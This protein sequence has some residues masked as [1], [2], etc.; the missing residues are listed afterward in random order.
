MINQRMRDIGVI[1]AAGC[2]TPRLFAYSLTEALLVFLA[3]S[4]VGA[5]AALVLLVSWTGAIQIDQTSSLTIVSIPLASFLVSYTVARIQVGRLV[6]RTETPS[7]ISSYLPRLNL[8]NLGKPL[9]MERFES[10][11]TLEA[12][13]VLESKHLTK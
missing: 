1:K 5:L 6:N 13:P 4:L 7:A 12:R 8:K 11:F 2:I 9:P 10:A 3:S